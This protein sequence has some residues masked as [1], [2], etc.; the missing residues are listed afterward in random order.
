MDKNN[1]GQLSCL[2]F[3]PSSGEYSWWSFLID[4]VSV[5]KHRDIDSSSFS[6]MAIARQR[7]WDGEVVNH[8]HC[9]NACIAL[10]LVNFTF[11]FTNKR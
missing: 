8:K 9:D 11:A 10:T 2:A 3:Q 4:H 7:Q 1:T 6:F 5:S